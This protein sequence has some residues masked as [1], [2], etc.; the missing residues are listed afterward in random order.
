[1]RV[2]WKDNIG[3]ATAAAKTLDSSVKA[4]LN[5]AQHYGVSILQPNFTLYVIDVYMSTLNSKFHFRWC[6]STGGC[7]SYTVGGNC[8]MARVGDWLV[9]LKAKKMKSLTLCTMA[10]TQTGF[11]D[12]CLSIFSI[13]NSLLDSVFDSSLLQIIEQVSIF[14]SCFVITRTQRWWVVQ[15][16]CWP[17]D[18]R[19]ST[20]RPYLST[21]KREK[22]V[23][24]SIKGKSLLLGQIFSFRFGFPPCASMC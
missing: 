18:G 8:K 3:S 7:W 22:P 6:D 20:L 9:T 16:R 17:T 15:S 19:K 12:F 4:I 10:G 11:R 1:M 21:W 13:I 14:K 24:L 2:S 23:D 5:I